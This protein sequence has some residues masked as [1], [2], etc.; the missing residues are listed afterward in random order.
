MKTKYELSEIAGY[1]EIIYHVVDVSQVVNIRLKEAI[2]YCF[3]LT[4][5]NSQCMNISRTC[6]DFNSSEVFQAMCSFRKELISE[7]NHAKPRYQ[8]IDRVY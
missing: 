4:L 8:A 1:P 5:D 2:N 7:I 6:N 3:T